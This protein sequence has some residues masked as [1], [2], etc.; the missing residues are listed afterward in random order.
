VSITWYPG[1]PTG[2]GAYWVIWRGEPAPIACEVSP[3]LMYQ[4]LDDAPLMIKL[5]GGVAYRL[6]T[7]GHRI[8]HHAALTP[9]K[10]PK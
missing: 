9:P 6:G 7:A 4:H 5:L 3:A 2:R 1:P 8:T 10:G